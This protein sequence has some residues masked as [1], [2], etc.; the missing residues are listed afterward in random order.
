MKLCYIGGYELMQDG[1]QEESVSSLKEL[2]DLLDA[3]EIEYDKNQLS[4][5]TYLETIWNNRWD[6]GGGGGWIEGTLPLEY[7]DQLTLTP[8]TRKSVFIV[9]VESDENDGDYLYQ[10]TEIDEK[11]F[12]SWLPAI[13]M[14]NQIDGWGDC[15]SSRHP[16]PQIPE[17]L[18]EM[19][20]DLI[21]TDSEGSCHSVKLQSIEYVDADGKYFDVTIN[22]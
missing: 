7:F 4:D 16:C 6:D 3:Y 18:E 8:S 11:D 5:I 15:I 22:N 21:P 14:L 1:T 19:L 12:V 2:C 9:N 17:E 20:Y 13:K 10:T